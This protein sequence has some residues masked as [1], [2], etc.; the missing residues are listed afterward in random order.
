LPGDFV[1]ISGNSGMGKTTIINL[2]L[3]FLEQ[4]SGDICFNGETTSI[5]QR[6]AF[7][8]NISY[9]KQQPFLINDSIFKN[10]TLS[11]H[12]FHSG[13]LARAMAISGMDDILM[14]FTEGID[15]QITENGKNISGGQR[16]RIAL[17]RALYHDHDLLILDEPF[18][19]L[20]ER[21]EK[22]ILLQ[23][24]QLAQAGKMILF[25]THNRDSLA[26][27]NKIISFQEVYEA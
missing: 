4:G 9:V 17:A 24:Q 6:G 23:L 21:S 18:S 10:I 26:Y 12:S 19:E 11:D 3:G 14:R 15:K 27:C 7:C 25:I 22:Q 16:Q 13:K 5:E 2:L 1:G 20:D 8:T